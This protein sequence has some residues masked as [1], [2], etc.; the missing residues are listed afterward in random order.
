MIDLLD[1]LLDA[2]V[3]PDYPGMSNYEDL[4]Q[5]LM[6]LKDK[7]GRMRRTS[8]EMR[9]L[10]PPKRSSGLRKQQKKV[11]RKDLSASLDE[12]LNP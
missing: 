1:H 4:V 7:S 10:S 3:D 5:Y 9:S 8:S 2:Y 12:R 11:L 6:E